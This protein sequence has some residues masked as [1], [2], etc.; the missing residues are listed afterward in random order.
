VSKRPQ[1]PTDY[2]PTNRLSIVDTCLAQ[3]GI[4]APAPIYQDSLPESI[5]KPAWTEEDLRIIAE[6]NASIAE[7][8]RAKKRRYVE[9]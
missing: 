2:E 3:S 7:E 5:R 6:V 8:N 4:I 9:N 1:Y